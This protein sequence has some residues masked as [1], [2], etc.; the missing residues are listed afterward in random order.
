MKTIKIPMALHRLLKIRAAES[1][2]DLQEI[3]EE[4]IR[5]GLGL[6]PLEP[7]GGPDEQHKQREE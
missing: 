3:V 2:Q 5:R 1:G 7:K 6:P 4:V